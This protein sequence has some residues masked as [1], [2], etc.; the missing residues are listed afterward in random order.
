[1]TDDIKK[2]LTQEVNEG[3]KHHLNSKVKVITKRLDEVKELEKKIVDTTKDS[4][5]IKLIFIE[6]TEFEVNI[7]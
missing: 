3:V 2:L 1:M 7:K 4:D 5:K 6:A